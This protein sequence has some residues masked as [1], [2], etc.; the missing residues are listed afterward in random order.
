M[1]KNLTS[2]DIYNDIIKKIYN[3]IFSSDLP[4]PSERVLMKQYNVSRTTI[5]NVLSRLEIE[6][7]IYKIQGKGTFVSKNIIN[8]KLNNFYSFHNEMKALGKNP[9][10]KLIFY[11][12]LKCDLFFSEIFKVPINSKVYEI[13]RLR[14]IEDKPV[15]FEKTYIPEIRFNKFNFEKLNEVA[16]YE[17]FK[18]D[19]S[20]KF[21]KAV[22]TFKP[23]KIKNLE[24]IKL[25]KIKK[26]DVAMEVI[27]KTYENGKVIEYTIS[28][29]KSD[30]FEYT[31]ILN[32]F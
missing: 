9:S 32:N 18:N 30:I 17:I 12:I 13:H 4:I 24:E 20:V 16:M 5:R 26:N 28:H 23:I 15:I 10:S 1:E 3:N 25:L 31:V 6:K 29:V 8:Q 27:R 14:F 7:V 19:Y 2:Y 11:K 21:E 22:E